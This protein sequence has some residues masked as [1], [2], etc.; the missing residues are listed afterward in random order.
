MRKNILKKIRLISR[1]GFFASNLL[2]IGAMNSENENKNRDIICNI[3]K[4]KTKSF[5]EITNLNEKTAINFIFDNF[6]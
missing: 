2:N 5:S 1:Y 4:E 3:I 6:H